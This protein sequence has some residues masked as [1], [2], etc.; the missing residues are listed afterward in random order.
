M[1]AVFTDVDMPWKVNS[2]ALS[3]QIA[4]GGRRWRVHY[5]RQSSRRNVPDKQPYRITPTI[6]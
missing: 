3:G 2:L 5:L 1:D 6:V 4:S